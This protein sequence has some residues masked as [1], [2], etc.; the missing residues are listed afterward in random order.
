[1]QTAILAVQVYTEVDGE[2]LSGQTGQI[3]GQI[4]GGGDLQPLSIGAEPSPYF[5]LHQLTLGHDQG[6]AGQI[7]RGDGFSAGQLRFLADQ[8]PPPLLDRH[9]DKLIS[10]DVYRLQQEAQIQ[11][12]PLNALLDIVRVSAVDLISDLGVRLVEGGQMLRQEIHAAQ[13]AASNGDLAAELL[14][15]DKLPLRLF[16]QFHNLPGPP[17]QEHSLVGEDDPVLAPPEELDPQLLLQLHQLPGQGGLGQME[18]CCS[19]SDV[20]LPGYRQ[21]I[22]QNTKFHRYPSFLHPTIPVSLPQDKNA[23][24]EYL[25]IENEYFTFLDAEFTMEPEDA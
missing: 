20:F 17:P 14:P 10:A 24:T 3:I 13:I 2:V 22:S 16:C 7:F 8:H 21:E 4:P 6:Q 15:M 12:A 1:M 18:Q 25:Q 5:L 9:T 11:Y 23:C 19:L